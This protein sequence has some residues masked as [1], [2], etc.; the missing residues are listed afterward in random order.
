MRVNFRKM[1]C[2][3]LCEERSV[4]RTESAMQ[5]NKKS[6]A[7]FLIL[8]YVWLLWF[9]EKACYCISSNAVSHLSARAFTHFS[10]PQMEEFIEYFNRSTQSY[11]ALSDE[12]ECMLFWY[13]IYQTSNCKPSS[14][15]VFEPLH[16]WDHLLSEFNIWKLSVA[17]R[18]QGLNK[19]GENARLRTL[20]LLCLQRLCVCLKN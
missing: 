10:Q 13:T 15:P 14:L 4:W 6:L 19:M 7:I 20:V 3:C 8:D 17:L 11:I 2:V 16:K 9:K 1:L 12:H 18:Y 5:G